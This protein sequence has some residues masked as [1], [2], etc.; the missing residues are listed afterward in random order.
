MA[1]RDLRQIVSLASQLR[2]ELV[3]KH[4]DHTRQPPLPSET[5]RDRLLLALADEVAAL[6]LEVGNK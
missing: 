6:H 4:K 5:I 2:R 3:D 1:R